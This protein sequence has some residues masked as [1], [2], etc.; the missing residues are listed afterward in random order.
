MEQT[1]KESLDESMAVDV[2]DP[3]G[4]LRH[5]NFLAVRKPFEAGHNAAQSAL[6]AASFATAKLMGGGV[7]FH[8]QGLKH[9]FRTSKIS[10][11]AG[12]TKAKLFGDLSENHPWTWLGAEGRLVRQ[13][14]ARETSVRP[15]D[16]QL[17]GNQ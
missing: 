2:E 9:L 5:T 15:P 4:K 10:D 3:D 8:D 14:Q 17:G 12:L 11:A 6:I 16:P 7:E 1:I 13:V